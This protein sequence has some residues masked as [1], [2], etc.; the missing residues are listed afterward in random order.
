MKLLRELGKLC[1]DDN[2]TTKEVLMANACGDVISA[3]VA[4]FISEGFELEDIVICVRHAH[5]LM[6]DQLQ[7]RR[8]SAS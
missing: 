7:E 2:A 8:R 4:L 3:A 5:A 6:T 1:L